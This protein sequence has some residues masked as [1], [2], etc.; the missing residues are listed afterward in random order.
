MNRDFMKGFTIFHVV[1]IGLM[2]AGVMLPAAASSASWGDLSVEG[3]VMQLCGAA[4]FFYELIK[5]RVRAKNDKIS[6]R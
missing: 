4:S 1:G 6:A 3:N 5:R 2:V